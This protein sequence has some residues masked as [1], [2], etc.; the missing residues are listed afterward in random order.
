[1]QSWLLTCMLRFWLAAHYSMIEPRMGHICRKKTWSAN[2]EN[3]INVSSFALSILESDNI[4]I[5]NK[6]ILSSIL[7][8]VCKDGTIIFLKYSSLLH[9]C[10]LVGVY[11]FLFHKLVKY[12]S[13][14]DG[15]CLVLKMPQ[16]LY[17]MN[18]FAGY[19][20]SNISL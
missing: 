4:H 15:Y 12:E 8:F 7:A 10:L 13:I 14:W 18:K 16:I 2:I 17:L 20:C 19:L 1:M 9:S 6:P 3:L 11:Q 5:F